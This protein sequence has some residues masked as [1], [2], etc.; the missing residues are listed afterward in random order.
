MLPCLECGRRA[1]RFS[2]TQIDSFG[3]FKD[4]Y[5]SIRYRQAAEVLLGQQP[6]I[7]NEAEHAPR[8]LGGCALHSSGIGVAELGTTLL[9]QDS[10]QRISL[11]THA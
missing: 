9:L 11:R 7:D 4:Q 3:G 6:P 2:K 10:F 1:S 8:L 5:L